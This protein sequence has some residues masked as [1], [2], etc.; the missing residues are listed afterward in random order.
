LGY[1]GFIV[2][3]ADRYKID[4]FLLM[5][6]VREESSFD[7]KALSRS[8]ARGLMQLMPYTAEWISKR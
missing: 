6:I 7:P 8:G 5:A 4:P 1:W 2:K 3:Y